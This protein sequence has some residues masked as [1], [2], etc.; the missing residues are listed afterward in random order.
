MVAR[1]A[2]TQLKYSIA[3]L[4]VCTVMLIV[5][6]VFPFMGFFSGDIYG[7]FISCIC[8][9]I[10]MITYIPILEFYGLS[11]IWAFTLPIS[12]ILYLMMTWTSA[13]RYF[14]GKRSQWKGRIYSKHDMI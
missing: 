6:F 8:L 10:M 14:T 11:K 4:I 9:I 2:F 5:S 1:S 12:G 7:F 13:L 3:L